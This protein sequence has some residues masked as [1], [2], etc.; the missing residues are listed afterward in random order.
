MKGGLNPYGYVHNPSNWI[1]PYGL[2]GGFGNK[3]DN[4]DTVT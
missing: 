2:A 1:D 4:G 3:G